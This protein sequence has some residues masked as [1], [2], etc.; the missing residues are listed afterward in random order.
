ML[1]LFQVHEYASTQLLSLNLFTETISEAL[2]AKEDAENNIKITGG[3]GMT[4]R[5]V[6]GLVFFSMILGF[7]KSRV[8]FLVKFIQPLRQYHSNSKP[9]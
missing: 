3:S 1:P 5:S 6:H 9:G 4:S 8:N 7:Y 2:D